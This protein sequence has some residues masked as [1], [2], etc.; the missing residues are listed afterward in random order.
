MATSSS[1][2]RGSASSQAWRAALW[3]G[4]VVSWLKRRWT[5]ALYVATW[6]RNSSQARTAAMHSSTV[7]APV[8]SASR[9][10]IRVARASR[11]GVGAV[12]SLKLGFTAGNLGRGPCP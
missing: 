1:V 12:T 9:A 8:R 11:S 3:P 2:Q 5:S 6:R 7:R 10:P 4:S